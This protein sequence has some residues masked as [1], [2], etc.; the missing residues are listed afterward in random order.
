MNIGLTPCCRKTG[1]GEI[2][3][4]SS[5]VKRY[6]PIRSLNVFFILITEHPTVNMSFLL[7]ID[8]FDREVRLCS[9]TT[10]TLV[11]QPSWMST[12]Q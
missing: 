11:L 4:I 2:Y 3:N 6:V 7:N 9:T 5:Y 1:T 8:Y 12:L 10:R